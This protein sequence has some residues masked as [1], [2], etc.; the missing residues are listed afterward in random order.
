MTLYWNLAI[1]D[2]I[3]YR[4][5]VIM[6]TKSI[7]N[8]LTGQSNIQ[9]QL[10]CVGKHSFLNTTFITSSRFGLKIAMESLLAKL[11]SFNWIQLDNRIRWA[12]IAL[13]W[14]WVIVHQSVMMVIIPNDVCIRACVSF[15]N[16]PHS[17][18]T[19]IVSYI[20]TTFNGLIAVLCMIIPV[21]TALRLKTCVTQ[22][23]KTSDIMNLEKI[24]DYHKIFLRKIQL[25]SGVIIVCFLCSMFPGALIANLLGY[26]Y[27]NSEEYT[28][29]MSIVSDICLLLNAFMPFYIWLIDAMFR[30]KVVS[31]CHEFISLFGKENMKD[32]QNQI[33]RF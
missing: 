11:N 7:S 23:R 10:A 4:S 25:M 31:T 33:V 15:L 19:D 17:D 29:T 21:A 14:L 12:C 20:G 30:Q 16:Y 28:I 32:D 9:T 13:C 6:F 5:A 26:L 3:S 1:V 2:I 8:E 18:F 22:A 27:P 24:K